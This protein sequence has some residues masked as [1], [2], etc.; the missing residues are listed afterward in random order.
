M[1]QK[2]FLNYFLTIHSILVLIIHNYSNSHNNYGY[3]VIPN[4]FI[5][6]L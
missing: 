1:K 6:V 2:C 5:A 4:G 3:I